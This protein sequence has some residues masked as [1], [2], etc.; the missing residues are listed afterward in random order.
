VALSGIVNVIEEEHSR[1]YRDFD[2]IKEGCQIPGFFD[3]T[4][5]QQVII[6]K[7]KLWYGVGRKQNLS[8]LRRFCSRRYND[9]DEQR[10]QGI[11]TV[12]ED[13]DL[14]EEMTVMRIMERL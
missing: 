10:E 1:Y 3:I 8:R 5:K 7:L 4:N 14:E 12:E 13:G 11:L 9:I 6:N 2:S